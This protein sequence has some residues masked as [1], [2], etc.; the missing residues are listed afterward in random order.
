[1]CKDVFCN[2]ISRL[3]LDGF[4]KIERD[5]TQIFYRIYQKVVKTKMLFDK[6]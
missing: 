1:M 4:N 5:P 6:V 2:Q 3:D